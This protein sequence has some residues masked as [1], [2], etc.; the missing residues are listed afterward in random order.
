MTTHYIPSFT[1]TNGRKQLAVCGRWVT[2]HDHSTE[3]NCPACAAWL[4]KDDAAF[5]AALAADPELRAL[6]PDNTQ[7][8]K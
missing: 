4:I 5:V 6:Y 8:K 3:P 1:E 2:R 7:E